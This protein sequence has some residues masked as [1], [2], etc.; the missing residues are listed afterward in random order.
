MGLSDPSDL[1]LSQPILTN[2]QINCNLLLEN[3]NNNNNIEI[4]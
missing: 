1:S 3:N 4:H 2:C